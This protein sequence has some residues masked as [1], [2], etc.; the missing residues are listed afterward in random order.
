LTRILQFALSAG[1]GRVE[2]QRFVQIDDGFVVFAFPQIGRAA[3][4]ISVLALRIETQR[5]VAI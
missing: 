5:L 2:A 4:E 1:V 3:I